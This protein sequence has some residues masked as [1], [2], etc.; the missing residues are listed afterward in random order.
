MEL[1]DMPERWDGKNDTLTERIIG[2]AIE[3]QKR[4]G[5]YLLELTYEDC[6]DI[7]LDLSGMRFER[8]A[9][10]PIVYRSHQIRKAYR[11]DLVVEN[12]VII[13]IK[14]VEKLLPAHNAQLMT[15]LRM[16]GIETGL[17]INFNA[18][19]LKSGIRRLTNSFPSFPSFPSSSLSAE[20]ATGPDTRTIVENE[21][22]DY[23]RRMK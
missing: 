1:R 12:Q 16:S 19:P 7:E 21:A 20:D 11:A 3:V 17:L 15:Y 18:V 8:Q 5:P 14:A 6:L 23:R 22:R 4:T 10:M 13:E 2:A 9:L